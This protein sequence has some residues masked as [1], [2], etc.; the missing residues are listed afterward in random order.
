MIWKNVREMSEGNGKDFD[1]WTI[2][3]LENL[4]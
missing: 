2:N 3:A 4:D 1:D